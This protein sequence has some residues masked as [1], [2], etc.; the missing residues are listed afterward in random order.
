M[1]CIHCNTTFYEGVEID[2][3][4]ACPRCGKRML[5]F[6]DDMLAIA[7]DE[8]ISDVKDITKKLFMLSA[9]LH[10]IREESK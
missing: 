8:L 2:V 10:K 5:G 1:K 6:Q 4:D 7:V 9:R 3:W